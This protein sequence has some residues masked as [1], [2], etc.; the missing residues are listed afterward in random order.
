[1]GFAPSAKAAPLNRLT[2]AIAAFNRTNMFGTP[3]TP[4]LAAA[5]HC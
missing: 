5:Q 2:A 3:V 1:V 4:G